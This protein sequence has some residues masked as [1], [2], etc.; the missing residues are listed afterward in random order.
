MGVKYSSMHFKEK[1][2]ELACIDSED[3]TFC[4]TTR[5]EIDPLTASIQEIGLITLPI[6]KE[7]GAKLIV[8]SG[9]RRIKACKLLGL[10]HIKARVLSSE[11][12]DLTSIKIA[13]AENALQRPLNLIEQARAVH[14]LGKY[15]EDDTAAAK[16]ASGLCLP[17]NQS[18]IKKLKD[19]YNLSSSL[20]EYVLNKTLSLTIALELGALDNH[21]GVAFADL[22]D[23][24]KTSLNK[25]KEIISLTK[26]IALRDDSSI[27]EVLRE[28][29]LNKIINSKDPD[30]AKKTAEIRSYLKQRRFPVI[31]DY[32][33][34]FKKLI[35][36]LRLGNGIKLVPPK[37]FEGK[38]YKLTIDFKSHAELEK[39]QSI[40][41]RII[42]EKGVKSMFDH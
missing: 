20:Q 19:L 40:L 36:V 8:V 32:E 24:L 16:I 4:I 27:L 1:N 2:I 3:K 41:N 10:V 42:N 34:N 28:N 14:L 11:V 25:Q 17:G 23:E 18:I 12:T 38:I 37:N 30:R 21:A 13:V 31:T 15:I 26:E 9:F 35:K 29:G 7:K 22:F 39:R 33:K 6:L 5:T